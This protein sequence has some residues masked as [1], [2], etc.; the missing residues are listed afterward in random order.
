MG[1]IHCLGL[2]VQLLV[3]QHQE[4]L[5]QK[6]AAAA[7]L[8]LVEMVQTVDLVVVL[9]LEVQHQHPLREPEYQ[10]KETRAVAVAPLIILERL[11]VRVEEELVRLGKVVCIK[12]RGTTAG[13]V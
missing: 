10:V 11:R 2:V 7:A 13:L 4:P 6:A 12:L 8:G 3:R 5:P 9:G 1:L